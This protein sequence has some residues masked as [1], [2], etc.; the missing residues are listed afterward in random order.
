MTWFPTC[1]LFILFAGCQASRVALMCGKC[2]SRVEE[3]AIASRHFEART[4]VLRRMVCVVWLVWFGRSV[5]SKPSEHCH[6]TAWQK[7]V[8]VVLNVTTSARSRL[9]FPKYRFSVCKAATQRDARPQALMAAFS[10]K[11]QLPLHKGG[12]VAAC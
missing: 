1:A 4:K 9:F 12:D 10:P 5:C 8:R 6:F 11:L 3:K 2:D 7:A